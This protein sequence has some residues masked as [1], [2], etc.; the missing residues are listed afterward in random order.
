MTWLRSAAAMLFSCEVSWTCWLERN[1]SVDWIW[2]SACR[3][4]ALSVLNWLEAWPKAVLAAA[5]PELDLH[6][7][8]Q[9][10]IRA[11]DAAGGIEESWSPGTLTLTYCPF[12]IST[13][14][15]S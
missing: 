13:C 1:V 15:T 9:L 7:G 5:M 14:V 2:S 3:R 4:R 8:D 6:G 12:A 11:E 10:L